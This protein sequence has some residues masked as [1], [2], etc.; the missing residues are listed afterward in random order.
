MAGGRGDGV[1]GVTRLRGERPCAR[2]RA[3]GPRVRGREDEPGRR[4]R[5]RV[6]CRGPGSP[7]PP[8]RFAGLCPLTTLSG[9]CRHRPVLRRPAWAP[10][11]LC[12]ARALRAP[13]QGPA[14]SGLLATVPASARASGLHE[15]QSPAPGP[16]PLPPNVAD[17]PPVTSAQA[18]SEAQ[19]QGLSQGRQRGSP[20]SPCVPRP[21]VASQ[22]TRDPWPC[23]GVGLGGRSVPSGCRDKRCDPL[24]AT[25]P[26]P[27]RRPAARRLSVTAV[28]SL[29][30]HSD[31]T[32][33]A[34]HF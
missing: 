7:S 33:Q 32:G 18:D 34:L 19:S 27:P 10:A 9:L 30:A 1:G 17:L 29:G 4:P 3:P 13:S 14:D 8:A 22:T 11:T 12:G 20:A 24:A 21:A 5:S 2:A 31:D 26:W 16:G 28:T 6:G 23:L 25:S 15:T